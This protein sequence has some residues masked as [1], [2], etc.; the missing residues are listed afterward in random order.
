MLLGVFSHQRLL[1]AVIH[2]VVLLERLLNFE[3]VIVLF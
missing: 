1:L 3:V 2:A